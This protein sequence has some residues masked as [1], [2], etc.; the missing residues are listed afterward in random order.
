MGRFIIRSVLYG[1]IGYDIIECI[2][3]EDY[4]PLQTEAMMKSLLDLLKTTESIKTEGNVNIPVSDITANSRHVTA[5]AVFICL[6]GARVDGHAFAEEAAQRGAAAIVASEKISSFPG[7]TVVYVR[8]T[9]RAMEDMAPFF[10][11]YPS[12]KMRMIGVT[13]TNGKTTTTHMVAHILKTCGFKTGVIG[14]VHTLIG[15]V[16]YPAKNTTPDVIDLQRILQ[17]MAE[18]GVTHVCMEVSSH[19]LVFGRIAGCEFDTAVFT[20]LTEDHLD[21][22]KTM[23]NYAK[24]KA[25][26]FALVSEEKQ[27]KQGKHACINGDDPYASL[28]EGAVADTNRCPIITYGLKPSADLY[29]HDIHFTGNASSFMIR[30]QSKEY[31]IHTKLAGRFNVYNALASMAS[32]L[33]EG[34]GIEDAI[35]G[36]HSFASVPGRFEIIDEGQRFGVIVDYAHTP[37]GLENILVTAREI[38]KGKVIVAFG[39]GGD[40]DRRKRPI[41]GQIAA[42]KADIIFVTSDNPRTE[43]PKRIIED[44]LAGIQQEAEKKKTTQYYVYPKRREAIKKAVQA[45]SDGDIVLIAGKG[46]EN[47]QIL[48]DKTIHFDDR[49]EARKAIRERID[50]I[51][52]SGRD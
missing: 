11:D 29:A 39:C 34:V 7:V 3:R 19:A 36:L 27:V 8:D 16:E 48:K 46:H 4:I 41:M 52:Y 20:N 38:T 50:G 35:H 43:D 51:I 5:G 18:K 49:E 9:R 28:M 40:R 15:D 47:Y 6:K 12:R 45:A 17:T 33:A 24:A 13:G 25:T 2:Y 32:A 23:D 42:E 1:V 21:F 10:F 37:D 31:Q 44:V 30:Y 26:L 14:T 22:H